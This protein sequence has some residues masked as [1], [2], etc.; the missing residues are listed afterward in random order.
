MDRPVGRRPLLRD[1]LDWTERRP[2]L[3]GALG[4]ALCRR[5]A[6]L[7]W[8]A[9]GVGRSVRITPAG[10]A[11]LRDTLGLSPAELTPPVRDTGGGRA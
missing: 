4:A 11:A 1:C 10:V 2:H 3:G 7:G 5:F 6:E 8:T 9:P